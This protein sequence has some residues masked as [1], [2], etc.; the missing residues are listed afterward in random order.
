MVIP[1]F[2]LPDYEPGTTLVSLDEDASRHIVQVLRMGAG[3]IL[4]LTDGCG[5]Q[6]KA[7]IISPN[8][9]HCQVRILDSIFI[10]PAA[11]KISIAISLL[12]NNDRFE[13][14][15]EKAT[16]IGITEIIPVICERTEKRQFRH[17]RLSAVLQSAMIQSQQVWLPR[18]QNP[19]LFNELVLSSEHAQKFIAHCHQDS[20]AALVNLVNGAPGSQMILIGPEGDFS[21]DEIK[22]A[23]DSQFIP[24]SLGETRLRSET[25]GVVAACILKMH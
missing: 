1:S 16:E 14:F 23:V 15:L 8:K 11:R 9:R 25:A 6:L 10:P 3:N 5:A 12:K 19:N 4:H 17:E 21:A 20:K 2:Y 18:L 7:E 13:W 22:L 24:V